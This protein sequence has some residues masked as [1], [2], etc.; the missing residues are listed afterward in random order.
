MS[1]ANGGGDNSMM[2]VV[3]L[4]GAFMYMNKTRAGV[5]LAPNQSQGQMKSLPGSVGTGIGQALG[6]ALGGWLK[7]AFNGNKDDGFTPKNQ[8]DVD[9]ILQSNPDLFDNFMSWGD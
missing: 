7:S 9:K 6:G 5:V 4:I 2:M 3:L 8:A 1:T